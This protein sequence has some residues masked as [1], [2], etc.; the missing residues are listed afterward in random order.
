MLFSVAK[1]QPIPVE[2]RQTNDGWQLLRGGEPYLIRGAGGNASLERL[3]PLGA[4]S[5]RTWGVDNAAEVLDEAHSHGLTVTLGI[6]L[7][8]ESEEL[9]YD[10]PEHVAAQFEK[11]RDAVLKYRDH[12]ALL[13][14]GVGNEVEGFA[15]GDDPA[16]WRALNDIAAMVKKLDPNHPTM[17]VTS[18]AGGG[19]IASL[20]KDS[21]AIDIHGINTYGGAPSL[22]ERLRKGGA[23]KPYVITEFGPLGAWE[24][25]KTK[26]GAPLEQTSSQKA[27]YYQQSYE[28]AVVESK[29]QALGSYAFL[30]G[31]KMEATSTWFGMLLDD[32][33]KLAA[34]DVMSEIWAGKPPQDLA[35]AIEPVEIDND[36][37]LEPGATLT[38]SVRVHDPEGGDVTVTWVLRP[39]SGDYHTAGAFRHAMPDIEGAV[40][41]SSGSKATIRMPDEQ[42]PYRLFAYAYDAAGN[43]A[44]ANIPLLVRDRS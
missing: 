32:G 43:A 9:D 39:E 38:A 6:W 3:A 1:A 16:T 44:T 31:S 40:V 41:E 36:T 8:H 10:N 12:P 29:G 24:V 7:D 27:A 30:W 19:R 34:A 11:A 2:L 4:N 21:P 37:V 14:W 18:E 15:A 26:W 23:T 42:G 33:A 28:K 20:H 5:V 35:P 22:A 17:V 13:L 25:P